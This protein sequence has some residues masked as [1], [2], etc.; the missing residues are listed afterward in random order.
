MIEIVTCPYNVKDITVVCIYPTIVELNKKIIQDE[1]KYIDT[2]KLYFTNNL[3]TK[4]CK[5]C[6]QKHFAMFNRWMTI[7]NKGQQ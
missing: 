7:V 2:K 3:G 1:V 6:V 5:R 4:F